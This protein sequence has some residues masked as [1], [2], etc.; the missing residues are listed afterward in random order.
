MILA[1][2]L[3]ILP[4]EAE[5]ELLS[6]QERY[7]TPSEQQQ[8]AQAAGQQLGARMHCMRAAVKKALSEVLP[9]DG[10]AEIALRYCNGKFEA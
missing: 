5:K 10:M 4:L 1:T 3:H 8:L 9:E 2:G 7:F 6:E